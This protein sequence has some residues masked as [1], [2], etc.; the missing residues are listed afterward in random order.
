[1]YYTGPGGGGEFILFADDIKNVS[2]T[3]ILDTIKVTKLH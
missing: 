2:H 3:I 1:M